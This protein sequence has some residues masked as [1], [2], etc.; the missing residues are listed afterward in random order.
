MPRRRKRSRKPIGPRDRRLHALT[1]AQ[2]D[3]R[4]RDLLALRDWQRSIA[5]RMH[6]TG[7]VRLRRGAK[8]VSARWEL[9][10]L[11]NVAC[12]FEL[13]QLIARR[14]LH[15]KKTECNKLYKQWRSGDQS[16]PWPDYR[17]RAWKLHAQET[18]QELAA[19]LLLKWDA[20]SPKSRALAKYREAFSGNIAFREQFARLFLTGNRW[21]FGPFTERS[22]DD[23]FGK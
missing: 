4:V 21:E 12:L 22:A 8:P 13:A 14:Q 16:M 11:L 18:V 7:A 1:E 9:R 19:K 2:I 17:L 5:Q 3:E 23:P 10:C 15:D 20:R 6:E